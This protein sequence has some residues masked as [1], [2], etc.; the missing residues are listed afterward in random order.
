MQHH[1]DP[2]PEL[3]QVLNCEFS[4]SQHHSFDVNIAA[5][6]GIPEAILI[7][8]FIFWISSNQRQGKAF[9]EGRTWTYQTLEEI[10]S[11]FPY[12]SI[13]QVKRIVSKLIELKILIKGN[14]NSSP[15]DHT[16]WYAFENEKIFPM[17]RNRPDDGTESFLRRNGIVPT[18][19][20]E[21]TKKDTKKDKSIK[22]TASPMRSSPPSKKIERALH[23]ET[24]EEDHQ[25]LLKQFG[26]EAVKELY[27]FLSEWKQDTPRSKWKKDDYRSILRWVV[28]AVAE[29]K[30]KSP[31]VTTQ[32]LQ[33]NAELAKKIWDRCKART[34][35]DVSLSYNYIEFIS[36]GQSAPIVAQFESKDFREKCLSELRKR[37]INTDG[38]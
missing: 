27:T 22:A 12:F 1:N 19:Q 16:P 18:Y 29:R 26:D 9:H 34:Q 33:T 23:V 5:K 6:Y 31:T 36:G 20:G 30:F 2:S 8:H 28:N 17:I 10:S 14:F 32:S 38:L 11:H 4:T 15:Y 25:K 37:K 35:M 24:S 13:S 21:D 3:S 7:H